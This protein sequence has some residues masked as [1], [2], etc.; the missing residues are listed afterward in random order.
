[1]FE[2]YLIC[3]IP[4]NFLHYFNVGFL[5]TQNTAFQTITKYNSIYSIQQPNE[6][7]VMW[8]IKSELQIPSSLWICKPWFNEQ[9]SDNTLQL[10]LKYDTRELRLTLFC[11]SADRFL[12]DR[13]LPTSKQWKLKTMRRFV[14]KLC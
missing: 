6:F 9:I 1:M 13:L 2:N 4:I 8:L 12:E 11:I 5:L 14:R 7:W 3:L 10:L